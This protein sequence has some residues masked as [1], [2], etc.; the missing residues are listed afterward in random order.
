MARP[1][2]PHHSGARQRPNQLPTGS[3]SWA[4]A[5]ALFEAPSSGVVD[6]LCSCLPMETAS[7]R[8][9]PDLPAMRR[10]RYDT[11]GR[12]SRSGKLSLAIKNISVRPRLSTVDVSA[13]VPPQRGSQHAA[14]CARRQALLLAAAAAV[15]PR[16]AP[17]LAALVQFPANELRNRYI[18]VGFSSGVHARCRSERQSPRHLSEAES[19][20]ACCAPLPPRPGPRRRKPG[21]GGRRHPDQQRVE[22]QHGQW[23]L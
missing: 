22:D 8:P 7:F 16:P 10:R 5:G 18:L 6:A 20:R 15:L 14:G 13:G 21:A 12:Q 2:W 1:I 19:V 17:A 3:G 9:R 11:C 23:P 4:R